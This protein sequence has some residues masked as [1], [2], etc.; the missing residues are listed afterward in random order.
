M[1]FLALLTTAGLATALPAVRPNV[2]ER[3]ENAA[4]D[5]ASRTDLEDGAAGSCPEVIFIFARASTEPGNMGISAGPNVSN[6]LTNAYPNNLWV[7]GVGEPYSAGLAENF[8]PAG[9]S[10]DAIDEAKRMYTMANTKCP[11]AKVVTGGYSQGTAVVSN[12]LTQLA[13]DNKA[14]FDQVVGAVLFGYTKNQ[15]NGGVIPGYP[16]ERTKVF[17]NENDAV[18][19]GTLFILP[20]H[21]LYFDV[22]SNEGPAFLEEQINK[23]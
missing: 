7:Q 6:A 14:A 20:D 3:A 12:A 23:A 13:G 19:H 22:A 17:C 9:T 21:F 1:K 15:Q 16:P 18:C 5:F 8:L 10:Q 4:Q 2:Q 11:N